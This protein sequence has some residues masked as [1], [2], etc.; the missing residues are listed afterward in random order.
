[1]PDAAGISVRWDVC[2]GIVGV[3]DETDVPDVVAEIGFCFGIAVIPV[4]DVV[5]EKGVSW[6]VCTGIVAGVLDAAVL[7]VEGDV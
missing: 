6:R 7:D 4:V 5:A 3:A 2:G 1:M